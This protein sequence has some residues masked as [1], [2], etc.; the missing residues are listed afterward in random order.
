MPLIAGKH[1]P[2]AGLLASC[3]WQDASDLPMRAGA[4][5][6][7]QCPESCLSA[8]WLGRCQVG[9]YSLAPASPGPVSHHSLPTT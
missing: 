2:G 1:R 7:A 9:C 8:T 4:E 5:L 3:I 6:M